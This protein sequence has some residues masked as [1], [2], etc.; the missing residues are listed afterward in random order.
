MDDLGQR[1]EASITFVRYSLTLGLR[2]EEGHF[3][4]LVLLREELEQINKGDARGLLLFP[5]SR[6]W[7]D[8]AIQGPG[9]RGSPFISTEG[10][11]RTT[12][13]A[14]PGR[15]PGELSRTRRRLFLAPSCPP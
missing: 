5:H 15:E 7:R 6:A 1:A 8:F 14:A 9:R 2:V 10:E 13:P 4:R 3:P 12:Y 11:G